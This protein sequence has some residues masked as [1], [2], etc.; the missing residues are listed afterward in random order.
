MGTPEEER[1]LQRALRLIAYVAAEPRVGGVLLLDVDGLLLD[2]VAERLAARL[3]ESLPGREDQ[4]NIPGAP[5][6]SGIATQGDP[7][8]DDAVGGHRRTGTGVVTL[9]AWTRE[10]HLWLR[11]GIT[12]KGFRQ[13][14]G[15]LVEDPAEPPSVIV[16]PD[17]AHASAAVLRAAVT[18]VGATVASAETAGQSQRWRP[19][20]V[21]LAGVRKADASTLSPHLT[22]RFPIRIDASDWRRD[23]GG[24][25]PFEDLS[26]AELGRLVPPLPVAPQ[27]GRLPSMS[28][29]AVLDVV[30]RVPGSPGPRRDL[31]LARIARAVAAE[32]GASE[33]ASAHVEEA[34][35]LL[36]I[37]LAPRAAAKRPKGRRARPPEVVVQPVVPGGAERGATAPEPA[38]PADLIDVH[39]QQ[40]AE[41][42]ATPGRFDVTAA[43]SLYIEDDPEILA[44]R[45]T[46]VPEG[47]CS[48]RRDRRGRAV[49]VEPCRDIHDI[50]VVPTL[51]E[52]A[53]FQRVRQGPKAGPGRLV[54]SP[55][56][57]RQYRKRGRAS[58]ALVL[59]LDHSCRG[60]WDWLPALRRHLRWAHEVGAEV[61]V[62]EL[63]HRAGL[64][65]LGAER[66]RADSIADP[67]VGYALDRRP[68]SGTA[69]PLAHAL[70]VAVHET[71]R[72]LR[73]LRTGSGHV[74]LVVVTDG[75]G[76]VPL[77]A[78][79]RR[80]FPDP[81]G[82]E[83]VEDALVTAAV[84]R[85]FKHVSGV[86]V[87][88]EVVGCPTLPG[89]LADAMGARLTVV[90]RG[91]GATTGRAS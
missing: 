71:R 28:D 12:P 33:V 78:S 9:G 44:P 15:L 5:A 7:G 84:L 63:G 14:P 48:A 79:L 49:G 61:V 10:E 17:L 86:V 43:V 50:A 73:H 29:A 54:L 4:G 60:D 41:L 19:R 90:R 16:V 36:D 51:L 83:G 66:F 53:K 31:A 11:M 13:R 35:G 24:L 72:F 30:H 81:I 88:P 70:D 20:A 23:V 68:A 65:A 21:W 2:M 62:V 27:P 67:H 22:D 6:P 74:R 37:T 55:A 64:A 87:A 69:T 25:D 59:V 91:P 39:V 80:R 8:A 34:A 3:A 26:D 32:A 57:L 52:A 40:P 47:P 18:M 89:E 77:G 75:R 45:R 82:R 46:L 56:D 76:N 1:P 85:S 38:P 58:A 42:P